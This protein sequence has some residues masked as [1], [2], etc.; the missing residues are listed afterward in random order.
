MVQA[1]W[2]SVLVFSGTFD[3]LTDTLIFVSWIYYSGGG[4]CRFCF[5]TENARAERPFRVPGYPLVP[6]IFVV[7]ATAFLVLTISNDISTFR[8][9]KAAG[10]PPLAEFCY[11]DG[12]CIRI[13]APL[14]CITEKGRVVSE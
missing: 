13:G 10:H 2:S 7:F 5:A 6:A 3:T 14:T 4:V 11:G 8:A 12:A 9:A 1:I